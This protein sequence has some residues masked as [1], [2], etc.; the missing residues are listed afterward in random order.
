[1]D[2]LLVVTAGAEAPKILSSFGD[3][4]VG[5]LKLPKKLLDLLIGVPWPGS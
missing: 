2:D 3:S 5:S 1:M 4:P